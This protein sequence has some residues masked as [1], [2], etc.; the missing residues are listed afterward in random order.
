MLKSSADAIHSSVQEDKSIFFRDL[1]FDII[2]GLLKNIFS[3]VLGGS[4]AGDFFK[5]FAEITV[6][7]VARHLGDGD[8]VI[9][10]K[11]DHTHGL[12][13]A[14]MPYEIYYCKIGMLFE[15]IAQIAFRHGEMSG[16]EGNAQIFCIVRSNKFL[17]GRDT[18]M[19]CIRKFPVQR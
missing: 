9:I 6:A 1:W 13:N 11:A 18:G 16:K 15:Y 12:M 10:G 14:Y 5:L 4:H 3:S 8:V 2:N 7:V 17:Y 19:L